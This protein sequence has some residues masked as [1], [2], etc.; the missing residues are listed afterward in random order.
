M[1]DHPNINI[2]RGSMWEGMCYNCF[3]KLAKKHL[4]HVKN[5]DILKIQ[6][7]EGVNEDFDGI[8]YSVMSDLYWQL[9]SLIDKVQQVALTVSLNTRT[10]TDNVGRESSHAWNMWA[11]QRLLQDFGAYHISSEP[12]PRALQPQQYAYL[13]HQAKL[14]AN[15]GT[16]R[17]SF[18][19]LSDPAALAQL[20][21]QFEEWQAAPVEFEIR[22]VP[23]EYCKEKAPAL[24]QS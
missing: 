2:I 12:G 13:L 4:L 22:G 18:R 7:R 5:I 21:R 19:R 3:Y 15:V 17:V 6:G 20:R 1:V 14:D 23:P 11:T 24:G 16:Y 9:P 10:L 8:Q